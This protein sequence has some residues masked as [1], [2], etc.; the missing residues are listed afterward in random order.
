MLRF[1]TLLTVYGAFLGA[2]AVYYTVSAF[3]ADLPRDLGT[4]L[5]YRPNRA[6]IVYSADGEPIGEFFLEKRVPV[7]YERVPEH[8]R[9]AF[10][11]AEDARFW[12][13][14]GFDLVGIARAAWANYQSGA[15][16]Q[17]ASTITQQVTRML[18]LSN[19]RTYERKIK[20]LILS[21]RVER[22]LSK[23]D[24]LEIY[25]NHVYLGRGAYGVEAAAEIYFGKQVDH[26]SVAEAAMLAG[27][28]QGPS[29]YAPHRNMEA[30]RARQDYVLGRMF[31]DGYITESQIAAAQSEPLALVDND[32]PLNHVAAPYFVEHIRRLVTDQ[33]GHHSVFYGG[34]RI[35]TSLDMRMQRAAEA[36]VRDGLSTL[37]RDIGF[38]GPLGH[39]DGDELAAFTEGPPRPYVQA[40]E[41]ATHSTGG[42]VLP[43]VAYV[44]AV[45]EI[46]R[47]GGVTVDLG[48]LELEMDRDDARQ[49]GRWRGDERRQRLAVGDLVP[50]ELAQGPD[51][52]P[53]ARL[54]QAPDVQGALIALDPHTGRVVAMVGGYDYVHSQ[55]NRTTQAN[56]QIGSAIKPFIYAAAMQK[57]RTHLD[58]LWDRRVA[59][60]T[61]AGV[62]AP[63][64][65]DNKY[66][67]PVT[68]R[69]ALAKSLNTIAVQLLLEVGVDNLIEL[70]R[71]LGIESPIPRHVSIA[72]GTPDLTLEEVTAAYAAFPNGGRRVEPRYIDRITSDNGTVLVDNTT[73]L[74]KDQILS[75]EL[76]YLVAN[77][78]EVVV[79]RG[80]GRSA[81]AIG[82]PSA[83]K[84][85]TATGHRDAW[86]LGYTTDL[87]AGV[88]VGRDDF[89]PIG[90]RATGGSAALPIWVQFMEAAHPA[91][92][93][94]EFDPPDDVIFVRANDITGSAAAPG[95]WGASWV[96]FMRGTVPERFTSKVD[97]ETF[98]ASLLSGGQKR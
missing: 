30:A 39:L 51:E 49:L 60:R 16:R 81:Q 27:L 61:L 88:W 19:E 89:T 69:T 48:P 7:P 6:S 37:D 75:P 56:R 83:G 25:L 72:L 98:R 43:S 86:F 66:L 33:F 17:G 47:R 10:I 45:A 71:G 97:A 22:E 52:Q 54:A 95:A 91:T 11:S 13:H 20:E 82:R 78:M 36:A 84:T 40:L 74:P 55:F 79:Q 59:V 42:T 76:A 68:L 93:P 18:L 24:I 3:A 96:P 58:V 50:V 87:V 4:A 41:D 70:M 5:D 67:G 65:Y 46:D 38:R 57:G 62:W 94:S 9:Q 15:T 77:L 31:E 85:G 32:R 35:Y 29:I 1:L 12:E 80:T 23:R 90:A 64:N 73:R 53:I 34:L 63:G 28:I 21:V 8:V 44:A 26:L 92:E 2:G 14:P